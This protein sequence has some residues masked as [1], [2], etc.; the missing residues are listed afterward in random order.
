MI[1]QKTGWLV[2]LALL[3]FTPTH[4]KFYYR[5]KQHNLTFDQGKR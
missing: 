3:R 2:G 1:T 4:G 5:Q